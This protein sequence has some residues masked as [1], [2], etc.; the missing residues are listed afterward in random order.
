MKVL[1]WSQQYPSILRWSRGA[2]SIIGDGILMKFKLIQAFIVV[3][4]ICKNKED[5][6]KIES[7]RV[8]RTFPPLKVYGFF[9]DA[10]GQQTHKSLVG[11][12]RISN[13]SKLLCLSLLDERMKKIQSKIDARA[14][15]TLSI[16][17]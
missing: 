17:F 7:N 14:V 9:P 3:I 16:N 5:S 2:N 13:S 11:S 8:V 12:C 4:L 6:F 10:Q 1:E 15:T